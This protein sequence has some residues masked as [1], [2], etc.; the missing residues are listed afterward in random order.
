MT[1]SQSGNA[2]LSISQSQRSF[3]VL[4][5]N[6]SR[7]SLVGISVVSFINENNGIRREMGTVTKPSLKLEYILEHS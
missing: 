5:W 7:L 6:P 4:V 3:E 1:L 2:L